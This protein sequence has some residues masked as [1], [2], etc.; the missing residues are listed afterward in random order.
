M[1]NQMILQASQTVAEKSAEM[2]EKDPHGAIITFVSVS[3]VFIA[4]IILYFAYEAIGKLASGSIR[5]PQLKKKKASSQGQPSPEEMAA[6]AL[7]LDQE[8]NGEV[9]AAIGLAMHMYMNDSVH[10]TESYII[11][12][13]RK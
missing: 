12:I 5:L 3:V 10:D 1:N 13:K 9:H 8:M 11:T 6:I 7:A 2:L 4:L